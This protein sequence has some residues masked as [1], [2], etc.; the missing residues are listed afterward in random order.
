MCC[1]QKL[2][3]SEAPKYTKANFVRSS[4]PNPRGGVLGELTALLYSHTRGL[5][6]PSRITSPLLSALQVLGFGPCSREPPVNA[7]IFNNWSSAVKI[8]FML[9]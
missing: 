5:V 1:G 8:N 4:A 6:A 3:I 9:L 2:A 7:Y